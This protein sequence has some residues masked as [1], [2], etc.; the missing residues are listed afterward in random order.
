M[1][2][3]RRRAAFGAPDR[4]T[5]SPFGA[6]PAGGMF[7]AASAAPEA[8]PSDAAPAANPVAAEPT[9]R[10]FGLASDHAAAPAAPAAPPSGAAPAV[11]PFAAEPATRP[12]GA[13]SVL[14]S[15][16]PS[17]LPISAAPA[18][19]PLATGSCDHHDAERSVGDWRAPAST[20]MQ[21]GP[22]GTGNP[23][24][25]DTQQQESTQGPSPAQT[26]TYKSI[27]KMSEYQT[28]SFEELR[29]E[30]YAKLSGLEASPGQYPHPFSAI[31]TAAYQGEVD[32][33]HALIMAGA[34]I[35]AYDFYF[36]GTPL[37]CA[38]NGGRPCCVE[39]LI[40]A[41]ALALPQSDA[42][43]FGVLRQVQQQLQTVH[44]RERPRLEKVQALLTR[45]A[46]PK[47]MPIGWVEGTAPA[48]TSRNHSADI[49][50]DCS[51]IIRNAALHLRTS[52]RILM[53]I[54]GHVGT[55]DERGPLQPGPTALEA[56]EIQAHF[57]REYLA[58]LQGLCE[59]DRLLADQSRALTVE[60]CETLSH[61]LNDLTLCDE[62]AQRVR[63]L[64]SS[65]PRQIARARRSFVDYTI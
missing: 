5:A 11:K 35:H 9:T 63:D 48:G 8:S 42:I 44:L 12:F 3:R 59:R 27:T 2:A 15:A 34:D 47:A 45:S 49:K 41:G 18:L 13:S 24:Y 31:H 33:V 37:M 21:N 25:Q 46:H 16:T 52:H 61:R 23:P 22:K 51:E 60:L 4:P 32:Q 56:V 64:M 50:K 54:N 55:A 40:K 29:C 43:R 20:M 7:G 53:N 62:Y 6:A 30:D 57:S 28:K 26:F 38:A 39:L 36:G 19:N 65:P 17:P 1:T 10:P 58:V 14:F